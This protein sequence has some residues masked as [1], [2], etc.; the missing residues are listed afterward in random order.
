MELSLENLV[1][2][3][4]SF[5]EALPK[6]EGKRAHIVGLSGDLGAGKTTFVQLVARAL[7]VEDSVT[8]PTYVIAE[9]YAI[10]HPPFT[11]LVHIDA[12]RLQEKESHTIGWDDFCKDPK[13]L[14]LV[15]W[16]ERLGNAFPK[17][18]PILIFSVVNE[19]TRMI[20]HAHG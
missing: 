6:N 3:A 14:L 10:E 7:G 11:S 16:P 19:S 20:T 13:N 17:D 1:A 9:R 8:S 15:E 12:Y 18:A 2:F 5:V 4:R